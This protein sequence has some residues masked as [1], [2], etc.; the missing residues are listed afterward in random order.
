MQKIRSVFGG[1]SSRGFAL[2]TVLIASMILLTMLTVAVGAVNSSRVALQNQYYSQL[3]KEASEAGLQ[4][5]RSCIED[6]YLTWDQTLRPGGDCYGS[7]DQC[8]GPDCYVVDTPN[9]RTRFE[10]AAGPDIAGDISTVKVKGFTERTRS[11]T[12]EVW[13]SYSSV[14]RLQD[15]V[16][17]VNPGIE[18]SWRQISQGVTHTCAIA[19]DNKAYC[20][21]LNTYGQLG[22]GTTTQRTTPTAVARGAMPQD[23]TILSI[24][25]GRDTTCAIA[26]DNKAYCWGFNTNG[27]LGDGST[28]QRNTPVAVAQGS[29]PAAAMQVSQIST[30]FYHTCA[31]GFDNKAYCWGYNNY[32]QLGD[33]TTVQK[34]AP[35]AVAQGATP[36]GST[37]LQIETGTEQTC[38]IASNDKAYC[39]GAGDSGRLGTGGVANTSV[40]AA[41]AQ[42]AM[43]ATAR[44]S[45]LSLGWGHTCAVTTDSKAYCWGSGA[46]GKLGKAL[47]DV[48]N[49]NSPTLVN[50]ADIEAKDTMIDSIS[51]SGN[52]VSGRSTCAVSTTGRVYCWGFNGNGE[53]GDSSTTTRTL[54]VSISSGEIPDGAIVTQVSAMNGSVCVLTSQEKAYCWG[55]NLEGRF[56]RGDTTAS[57]TPVSVNSLY[58]KTRWPYLKNVSAGSTH[59]CALTSDNRVYCWGNNG[60]GQLGDGTTIQKS[61]P[62]AVSQGEIPAGVTIRQLVTGVNYTCVLASDNKIYCW[63]YSNYGQLGD[64]TTIQKSSPV[65]VSQGEIPAGVTIRQLVAG[66]S[67]TC[68]LTSDNKVYCWGYNAYGQA[69]GSSISTNRV[70]PVAVFQGAIPSGVAIRQITAG[71]HNTC[72]LASDNRA[73]CWGQNTSGQLGD[74]T[75]VNKFSPVAVSQGEIPAGATIRQLTAGVGYICTLASD[76]KAYCWGQ[77]ANG[78]LGNGTA[79][80]K[81]SPVAVSQGEI[82]AG[83]TIRRIIPGINHTC[84]LTAN[85]KAYCWGY[86]SVG[87]LGDGTTTSKFYPAEV[88]TSVSFRQVTIGS[89]YTCTLASDSKAYCWGTNTNGQLGDGTT[90]SKSSPVAVL[91]GAIPAGTTI[92]QLT[93]GNSHTCTLASDNKAYCWGADITANKSSPVAVLQGAIPDGATIRQLTAGGSHSCALASDNKAY[94]WG[95]GTYSQL[96][97]GTAANKSS[98]V[99]V[100][101]GAIPAGVTIRQVINGNLHTCALASDNKAYCWGLGTSSQLGDGTTVSKSSPVAVLQGAIPAGTTIR[102]LATGT[103][104]TCALASDNKAYCWGAGTSGQLGDGTTTN[105]SS[106]VAVLQGA[107]PAGT[108]IRQLAPGASHTCALASDNKA[109]CWGAGT[110]SQLGDGTTVSKSSPVAVLQGA[111][112][113][114]TTIRQLT[115]GGSHTCALASDNK[116]YCWGLGTS[117][118]LGDGTMTNKSS[119]VAVLQGAIPDGVAIG[120]LTAGGSHTCALASDN[121]AYCWGAG[122]SGQLGDGTTTNKS[123]P[124]ATLNVPSQNY[125]PSYLLVGP[126]RYF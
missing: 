93:A 62:V 43:A 70:T 117:S 8:A 17:D 25:A 9:V 111:I 55:A 75:T 82:P 20:W 87:Q 113:A 19:S 104:H 35:V 37:A 71:G 81:F 34:N 46:D 112:P 116:A 60:N 53:I 86:N 69:G 45:Q 57:R 33:N 41:V 107:I 103:N 64:G 10:V 7:S 92:R 31:I 120:Q 1:K 3:A 42:G 54:P 28:T 39:W 13:K 63:G 58:D 59:A 77:N 2:P 73:Y 122:T 30:R 65:A 74:G 78:R 105:K 56:G 23:A 76:N 80:D 114:G 90:V 15:T 121:K 16:T 50:F 84:A 102:Q 124:V 4:M 96:G 52:G 119:P 51:A 14:M 110:S 49:S 109:Y 83:V 126:R 27:T 11:S 6:G 32:G 94:C 98:P 106:P 24:T 125:L 100:L 115:A 101:Q 18:L 29:R 108:T 40:P 47:N 95:N 44:V 118:Q 68:A 97:D 12:G 88:L 67:H 89:N 123:S 5:A 48:T 26:S 79:D 66:S 91:Q 61:S 85:N 22:D 21:G 36:A 72:A 99:A 38:M